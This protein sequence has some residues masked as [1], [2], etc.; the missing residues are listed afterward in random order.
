MSNSDRISA[1][2]VDMSDCGLVA[3]ADILADRWSVLVLRE[4]LYGVSRFEDMRTDLGIPKA[5]LTN[6]LK[7]LTEAGLLSVKSYKDEGRRTRRAYTP[8]P[9]ARAL[10][11]PFMALMQ[12]ADEAVL[13]RGSALTMASAHGV[14][15]RVAYVDADGKAVAP[16]DVRFKA[17]KPRKSS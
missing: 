8:T 4:A 2:P 14:P 1:A 5:T 9:A 12:W 3:A 7:R 17:A 15:V 16:A 13:H 10:T 6:R 11:L